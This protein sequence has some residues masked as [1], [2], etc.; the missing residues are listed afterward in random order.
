MTGMEI[1]EEFAAKMDNGIMHVAVDT[2]DIEVLK[3]L[4]FEVTLWADN[5][6]YEVIGNDDMLAVEVWG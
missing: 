3:D 1:L 4:A 6:D 5:T 2:D